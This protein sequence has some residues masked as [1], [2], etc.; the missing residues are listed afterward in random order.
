MIAWVLNHSFSPPF[1]TCTSSSF[2]SRQTRIVLSTSPS[3]LKNTSSKRVGSIGK[4]IRR[5]TQ[6][7]VVCKETSPK[8]SRSPG[9]DSYLTAGLLFN[10]LCLLP[11]GRLPNECPRTQLASTVNRHPVT[12]KQLKNETFWHWRFEIRLNLTKKEAKCH[13]LNGDTDEEAS[14]CTFWFRIYLP[15]K[16]YCYR[17]SGSRRSA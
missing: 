10:S 13:T 7:R 16:G 3:F 9:R 5:L 4:F 12:G 17:G 1:S 15:S 11:W 14:N 2:S 8:K 6:S